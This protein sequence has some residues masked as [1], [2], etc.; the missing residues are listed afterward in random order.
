MIMSIKKYVLILKTLKTLMSR[1]YLAD[2]S[3]FDGI[4]TFTFIKDDKTYQIQTMKIIS[5]RVLN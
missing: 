4:V 3:E 2:I 1:P 5:E